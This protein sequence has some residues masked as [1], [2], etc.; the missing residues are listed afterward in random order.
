M[1]FDQ[2]EQVISRQACTKSARPCQPRITRRPLVTT[3]GQVKINEWVS[4]CKSHTEL[5]EIW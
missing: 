2:L 4:R 1:T 5:R 3:R